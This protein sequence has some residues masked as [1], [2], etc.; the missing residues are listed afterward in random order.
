MIWAAITALTRSKGMNATNPDK[1]ATFQERPALTFQKSIPMISINTTP[2]IA[3]TVYRIRLYFLPRISGSTMA[4]TKKENVY[5]PKIFVKY[6]MP[7]P[8]PINTG[9]PIAPSTLI[10]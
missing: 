8:P 3:A 2:T 5:P 10:S 6:P 7:E 1:K 4:I 9:R